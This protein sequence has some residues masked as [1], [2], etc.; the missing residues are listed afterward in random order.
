MSENRKF[1]TFLL[2]F[3]PITFDILRIVDYNEKLY[4]INNCNIKIKY[5]SYIKRNSNLT[6]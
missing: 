5:I 2:G 6:N 1:C 4:Q 3:L